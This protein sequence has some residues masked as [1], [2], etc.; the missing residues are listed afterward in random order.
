MEERIQKIISSFGIASRRKAEELIAGG[1]VTVNGKKATLGDKADPARDH[2]K[3][4]GKLINA[5]AQSERLYIKFYKPH[6]VV[7]TLSDPEGRQSVGDFIRGIGTRVYPVGRLDYNSEGLLLLTNDGE[8]ANKIL[9]PRQKVPKVYHVK[10]KGELD[11]KGLE[12]LRKGVALEDGMT[13]PA[14]VKRLKK[15]EVNSWIEMIIYEGRKRQ[16]RRMLLQ[17][18]HPVAK[19]KRVS[20]GG[21]NIG[22]LKPGY[23]DF[24]TPDE[25]RRI[26]KDY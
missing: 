15:V 25:V 14:E 24:I 21:I 2:V 22:N 5:N 6:D 3:V 9:H 4:D 20:I 11:D 23:W 26:M 10:V 13:L 1:R 19:L 18:G 7:T 12:K 17:I 16:I 8:F